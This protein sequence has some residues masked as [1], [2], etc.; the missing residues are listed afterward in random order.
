MSPTSATGP[1]A[2][3]VLPHE[4]TIGGPTCE[5]SSLPPA[6]R[7]AITFAVLFALRWALPRLGVSPML[8]VLA[9]LAVGTYLAWRFWWS[10]GTDRRGPLLL[11]G[12]LWVAGVTKI[13]LH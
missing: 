6:A 12:T 2:P 11:I 3:T 7:L 4:P 10:C 5:R 9:L 13:L 1:D 8:Q